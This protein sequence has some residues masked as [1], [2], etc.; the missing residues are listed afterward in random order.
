MDDKYADLM[1]AS[2]YGSQWKRMVG[3]PDVYEVT[4]S[5]KIPFGSRN[6]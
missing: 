3:Y 2:E 5:I 1:M 6:T 4:N